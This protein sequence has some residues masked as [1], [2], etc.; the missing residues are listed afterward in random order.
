MAHSQTDRRRSNRRAHAVQQS[1]H[2]TAYNPRVRL[3]ETAVQVP[4]DT[5]AA[6]RN[7][8]A[9]TLRMVYL[10]LLS[11]PWNE[12]FEVFAQSKRFTR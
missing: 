8:G 6:P 2:R 4:A 9:E 10:E 5:D 7:L 3:A 11:Q 1:R 12:P